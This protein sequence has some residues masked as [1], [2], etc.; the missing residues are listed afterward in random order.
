WTAPVSLILQRRWRL[1]S[2]T[3]EADSVV[4]AIDPWKRERLTSEWLA[5]DVTGRRQ[6]SFGADITM[7]NVQTGTFVFAQMKRRKLEQVVR[8]WAEYF[9]SLGHQPRGFVTYFSGSGSRPV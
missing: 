9:E 3:L 6:A 7:A 5:P 1:P 2:P 8:D 4:S